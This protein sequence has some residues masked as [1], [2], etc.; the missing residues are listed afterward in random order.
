M[1]RNHPET[2]NGGR[3]RQRLHHAQLKVAAR[4]LECQIRY[5]EAAV[6][7]LTCVFNDVE[8]SSCCVNGR[9][10]NLRI[11]NPSG[12]PPNI[13]LFQLIGI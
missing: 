6:A 10:K 8:L 7:N 4:T 2:D 5:R 1:Q 13:S 11:D 3:N 9:K 12:I